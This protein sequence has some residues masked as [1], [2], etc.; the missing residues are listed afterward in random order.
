MEKPFLGKK[1]L[2]KNW[3]GGRREARKYL[4]FTGIRPQPED[5]K[6]DESMIDPGTIESTTNDEP[7]ESCPQNTQQS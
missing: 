1:S 2:T 3:P 6:N 7:G 4:K 5:F